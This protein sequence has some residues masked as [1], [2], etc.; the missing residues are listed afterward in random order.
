MAES[1][2]EKCRREVLRVREYE[3]VRTGCVSEHL[4][5][6]KQYCAKPKLRKQRTSLSQLFD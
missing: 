3:D 5:V 6:G 4:D 2:Q 1:P